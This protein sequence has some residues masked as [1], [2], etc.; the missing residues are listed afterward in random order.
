MEQKKERK[1]SK[2]DLHLAQVRKENPEMKLS[3]AMKE[4]SKNY[5]K[6]GQE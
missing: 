6:I 2:W 3:E 1:P 4:A 5:K